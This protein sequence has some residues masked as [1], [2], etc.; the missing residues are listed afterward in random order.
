MDLLYDGR[1][2]PI[3]HYAMP[4]VGKP[5]KIIVNGEECEAMTTKWQEFRNT[6]WL[7]KNVA[8]YVREHLPEGAVCRIDGLPDNFGAPAKP[9]MRKSYYKPKPK[10]EQPA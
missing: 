7:Y 1:S 8:M 2:I 5:L 4:R 10:V 6:Y 3:K 9:S